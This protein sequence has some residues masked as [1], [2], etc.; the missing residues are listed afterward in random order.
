MAITQ[1]SSPRAEPNH[2]P[3]E[4]SSFTESCSS[5]VALLGSTFDDDEGTSMYSFSAA[6]EDDDLLQ[7]LL[8][9]PNVDDE[10]ASPHPL[11]FQ[12]LATAHN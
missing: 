11:D 10:V 9:F 12:A 4:L 8:N 5:F 1:A 7:C 6:T 3:A 2:A